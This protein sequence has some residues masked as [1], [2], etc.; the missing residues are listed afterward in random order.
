MITG[1]SFNAVAGSDV[2]RCR[3]Y[4]RLIFGEKCSLAAQMVGAAFALTWW[5]TSR[6]D[7]VVAVDIL[8]SL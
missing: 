3:S 2:K 6:V 8:Q 5:A 7:A 1:I 4:M